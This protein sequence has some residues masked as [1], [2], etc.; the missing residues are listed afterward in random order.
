MIVN[1][2]EN[3]F[4]LVA[5]HLSFTFTKL[6]NRSIVG[7]LSAKDKVSVSWGENRSP[8]NRWDSSGTWH[9]EVHP[10]CCFGQCV[11]RFSL[12]FP[13]PHFDIGKWPS[14]SMH[15]EQLPFSVS[16]WVPAPSSSVWCQKLGPTG[17]MPGRETGELASFCQSVVS[18]P[19]QREFL[20]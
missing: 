16:R 17:W 19:A 12:I 13:F 6:L 1:L 2:A 18:L 9:A 15:G 5:P 11:T 3:E 20:L 10:D 7:L 14:C 8:H 4:V